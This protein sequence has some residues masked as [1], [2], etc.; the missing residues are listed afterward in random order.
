M[1]FQKNPSFFLNLSNV[2]HMEAGDLGGVIYYQ[3]KS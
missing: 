2:I 3:K 1:F